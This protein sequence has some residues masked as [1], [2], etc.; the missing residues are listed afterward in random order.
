MFHLRVD[1]VDPSVFVTVTVSVEVAPNS[2]YTAN[3][4]IKT[5]NVL[6]INVVVILQEYFHQYIINI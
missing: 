4:K 3:V 2:T 5:C 1:E 6:D